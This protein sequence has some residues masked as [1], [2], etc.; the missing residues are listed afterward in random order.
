MSVSN[1]GEYVQIRVCCVFPFVAGATLV[2]TRR[3][4]PWSRMFIISFQFLSAGSFPHLV[5]DLTLL[6]ERQSQ[7]QGHSQDWHSNIVPSGVFLP[8]IKFE[9]VCSFRACLIVPGPCAYWITCSFLPPGDDARHGT[10]RP[11]VG[12]G[13]DL[14]PCWDPVPTLTATPGCVAKPVRQLAVYASSFGKI[15]LHTPSVRS[16]PP[17]SLG[18]VLAC[19][20]DFFLFGT[21]GTPG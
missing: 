3:R 20:R 16:N 11:L 19:S 4:A 17:G 13:A 6:G 10:T 21:E 15:Q 2:S 8:S 12:R 14:S 5:G 7:R 18:G 9:C 1:E